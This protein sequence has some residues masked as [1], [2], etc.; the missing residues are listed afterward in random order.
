MPV[1]A[2]SEATWQ[3]RALRVLKYGGKAVTLDKYEGTTIS[4]SREDELP[5]DI[6]EIMGY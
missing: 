1:I 5:E 3:T 4:V 2:R 6:K